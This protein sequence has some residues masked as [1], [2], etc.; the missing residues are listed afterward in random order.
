[1]ARSKPQNNLTPMLP[2]DGPAT[3]SLRDAIQ[4]ALRRAIRGSRKS[5]EQIADE[6]S[7]RLAQPISHHM[8]NGCAAP[9][10]G[11]HRF[12][13]EWVAAFCR[14]TGDSSVVRVQAEALGLRI[15]DAD[16]VSFAEHKIRAEI[17]QGEADVARTRALRKGLTG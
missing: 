1:M 16:L 11:T 15:A 3:E 10:H 5:V 13:C 9:S 14:A 12:P 6:M 4:E 8:L 17:H 2:F 7:F